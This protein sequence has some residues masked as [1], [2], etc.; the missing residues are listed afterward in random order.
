V[1]WGRA[2]ATTSRIADSPSESRINAGIYIVAPHK[3]NMYID[4]LKKI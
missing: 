3:V 4:M 1:R 2:C